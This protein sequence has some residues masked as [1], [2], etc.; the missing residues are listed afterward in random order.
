[1]QQN[2][3]L[4]FIQEHIIS[5]IEDKTAHNLS[6]NTIST[7]TRIL[8]RF[9]DYVADELIKNEFLSIKHINQYFLNGYVIKLQNA[10]LSKK[11]QAL[12]VICIKKFI[13]YIADSDIRKYKYLKENISGLK[14]KT[15]QKE[16]ESFSSDDQKRI[17]DYVNLL[18]RKNTFLAN[19]N[20]LLIKMLLFTGVRIS[21]LLDIKWS[22]LMEYDEYYE[23]IIMGKGS[24]ERKTYLSKELTEINIDYLSDLK[25]KGVYLIS[26]GSGQQ[27]SRTNLFKLVNGLLVKAGVGKQG[28]HIFR[29][30]LARNL[31]EQNYNL[32][33]IKEVLGHS[34][35]STTAQFYAKA[36]ENAKRN[37]LLKLK[38]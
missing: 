4:N 12:Y 9:Y 14:I 13:W 27:C 5:Y 18:D 32:S 25:N 2:N 10:G 6:M 38:K 3:L 8:E 19:R 29:H 31:V 1:M 34:H 21:E 17:L 20:S 7:Y 28:L 33:T 35:I 26:S 11:S 24:K 23:I 22:D 36:D 15:E 16:K 30:T 37:A